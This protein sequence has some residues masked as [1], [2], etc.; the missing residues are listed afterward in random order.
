MGRPCWD[1]EGQMDRIIQPA[2]RT[3]RALEA[4]ASRRTLLRGAAAACAGLAISGLEP[5]ASVRAGSG[6]IL[7][8]ETMAAV[9]GPFVGATNPIRGIN[10]GGLPWII[11]RGGGELNASGH[12]EVHV[13]G[14]VLAETPPVPPA[15]RGTNPVPS[16]RAVVS[17]LSI[18]GGGA[19]TTV[20]LSTDTFRATPTGDAH[21]EA[22]VALP[23]PCLAPIIFVTSPTLSWFAVTGL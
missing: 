9:S 4:L 3:P 6:T 22:T 17:C 11:A 13:R 2:L 10:G 1:R 12:L 15:L 5:P 14:L 23:S 8:F 19:M 21:L 16:F 7:T 18:D 20:T